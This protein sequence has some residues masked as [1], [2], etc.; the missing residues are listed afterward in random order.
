MKGFVIAAVLG[1]LVSSSIAYL[2]ALPTDYETQTA[3]QKQNYLWTLIGGSRGQPGSWPSAFELLSLFTMDLHPSMHHVSDIM[4]EGRKKLIHSVGATA[5]VKF[6]WNENAAQYTGLFKSANYGILRASTAAAPGYS[7]V[8]TKTKTYT[9]GIGVKFLRN[10]KPSAN[11]VAMW[12]LS[13]QQ[14]FNFFANPLANHV[15]EDPNLP[16]PLQLLAKRFHTVSDWVGTVGLSDF[17]SITEDGETVANPNFPFGLVFQPNPEVSKKFEGTEVYEM[18]RA[19]VTPSEVLPLHQLVWDGA[20]LAPLRPLEEVRSFCRQQLK[21]L[22]E[23]HL[24]PINPTPYKVSVSSDLYTF[25]HDLWQKEA[26]V[27]E[28]S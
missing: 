12:S 25:I 6:V 10:G 23:D 5:K 17:A 18:K 4:P 8:F 22:R 27:V 1:L 11:F 26:P 13:G 19:Y 2:R 21:E 20:A 24:R 7:G 14:D 3:A 16:T 9:P 28:F 15:A